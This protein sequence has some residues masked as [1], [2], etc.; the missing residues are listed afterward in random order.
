MSPGF[1]GK[2]PRFAALR[3]GGA[4]V[5]SEIEFAFR[6][7]QARIIAVS[8]SNGKST[9]VSLIQHLLAGRRARSRLAG[10]IG[11]PLIAEVEAIAAG[12]LVGSGAVELPA[13]RD[14][15]ASGPRWRCCSTSPPTIS[16][17]IPPWPNTAAA[18][19]NL[20]ENQ[21]PE[22]RAWC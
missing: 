17:A 13:G 21:R 22:R 10:N 3:Q 9:T 6:Q 5:I 20:F 4:E 15:H 19:F 2:H 11:T 18:K 1:D 12:S 16:T 14:R 8:G 7:V